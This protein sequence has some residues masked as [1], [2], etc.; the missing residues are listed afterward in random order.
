VSTSRSHAPSWSFET[1]FYL[2]LA[3]AAVFI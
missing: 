1:E 2:S 3:G